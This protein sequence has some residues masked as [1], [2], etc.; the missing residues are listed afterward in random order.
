MD[1]PLLEDRNPRGG[2]CLTLSWESI[3]IWESRL[4]CAS[5]QKCSQFSWQHPRILFF[6]VR[7]L[8]STSVTSLSHPV[9]SLN[10]KIL[11]C[12]NPEL[13]LILMFSDQWI[14]LKS[15]SLLVTFVF[16]VPFFG[17]LMTFAMVSD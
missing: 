9:I 16:Y 3:P 5:Q 4:E 12:K 13:V 2:I 11:L 8:D 1:S 14:P 7:V 17:K 15:S 10:Q 6:L